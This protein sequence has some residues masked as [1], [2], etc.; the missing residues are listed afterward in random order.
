MNATPKKRGAPPK[1]PDQRHSRRVYV[2]V[3][4]GDAETLAKRFVEL[5]DAYE[6]KRS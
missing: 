3:R 5:R 1:P 4:P 2:Y 6:G